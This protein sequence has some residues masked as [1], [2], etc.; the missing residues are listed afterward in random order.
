MPD[1]CN[2]SI[3]SDVPRTTTS[4]YR[5]EHELL[6]QG[7]EI[8]QGKKVALKKNR[9]G[10]L[11]VLQATNSNAI[12]LSSLRFIT[13]VGKSA[14]AVIK[15]FTTQ[16]LQRKKKKIKKWKEIVMQEVECELHGIKQIHERAMEAQKQ[17]L[18]LELECMEGKVE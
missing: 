17:S 12:K 4:S 11:S 6:S 15:Q 18:Q 1:V 5:Q 13:T 3:T 16:E 10:N 14:E 8:I 7:K 9:M 2:T